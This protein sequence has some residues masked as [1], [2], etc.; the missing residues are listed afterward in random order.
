MS[1]ILR[2]YDNR[3]LEEIVAYQKARIEAL[4]AEIR[5]LHLLIGGREAAETCELIGRSA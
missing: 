5:R 2:E 1:T 4:Q 3:S